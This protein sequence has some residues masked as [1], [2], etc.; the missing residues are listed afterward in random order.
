MGRVIKLAGLSELAVP[1][2]GEEV[3]EWLA[4]ARG[5]ARL[6]QLHQPLPVAL[7]PLLLL[8]PDRSCAGREYALAQNHP[9]LRRA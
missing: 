4:W 2:L 3:A 8:H 6:L 5:K 7:L 1:R 9:S